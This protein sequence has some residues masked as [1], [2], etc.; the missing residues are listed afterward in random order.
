MN[1][2]N[3]FFN[4]IT[5]LVWKLINLNFNKIQQKNLININLKILIVNF[6]LIIITIYRHIILNIIYF[7]YNIYYFNP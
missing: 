3:Y 5:I 7:H 1:F 4:L 2:Y 6:F